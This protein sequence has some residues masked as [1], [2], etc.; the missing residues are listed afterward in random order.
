L[1]KIQKRIY[2]LLECQQIGVPSEK[3]GKKPG[4]MQSGRVQIKEPRYVVKDASSSAK[5]YGRDDEKCVIQPEPL[6]IP[7]PNGDSEDEA[8]QG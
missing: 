6:L 5:T 3:I 2:L 8:A 1:G 4:N 7:E